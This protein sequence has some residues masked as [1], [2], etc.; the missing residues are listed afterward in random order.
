MVMNNHFQQTFRQWRQGLK[1]RLVAS[2]NSQYWS[3]TAIEPPEL[4]HLAIADR[5]EQS[6]PTCVAR[7]GSIE[8][9]ILLWSQQITIPCHPF[10]QWYTTFDDTWRGATNAGISPRN[11]NSYQKFGQLAIDAL[12]HVDYLA[13]LRTPYETAVMKQLPNLPTFCDLEELAPSMPFYPHWIDALQNQ[14][15][16]IVSPFYDSIHHQLPKIADL[17]PSRNWLSNSKVLLHR[18]PYLIDEND[19]LNWWDVYKD[20]IEVLQTW[21]YD[22]ALFGCGGLGMPL[23]AFAKQQG[24]I[25]IQ[26]GGQLQIL[27]GVYGNRHVEQK[28]HQQC[29]NPAWIR[30][31][32]HEIAKSATRVENSCYW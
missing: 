22:V 28:W 24:K 3:R 21:E 17:W 30:P 29:I 19:E 26:L 6:I 11:P 31:F 27:F 9:E 7:I 13:V 14:R 2:P 1:R 10:G 20:M 15:I 23:A 8:A 32:P 25:G 5:I 4:T 16:L 18:F 12:D